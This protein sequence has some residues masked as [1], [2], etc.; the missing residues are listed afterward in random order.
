MLSLLKMSLFPFDDAKVRRKTEC[1][2][3]FGPFLSKKAVIIDANQPSCVR[4]QLFCARTHLIF[5]KISQFYELRD[6]KLFRT[7]RQQVGLSRKKG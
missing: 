2:I 6:G 1:C 7:T 5:H 3:T 4:T